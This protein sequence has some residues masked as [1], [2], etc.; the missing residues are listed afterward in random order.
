[1][2]KHAVRLCDA[3]F[4]NIYHLD[5]EALHLVATQNAPPAFAEASGLTT[6]RPGLKTPTGRM[7]ANKN[8]VH[9]ADLRAEKAYADRDPWIVAGVE[10]GGVRTVL[11]APMLKEQELIGA[12]SV[13][14]QKVQP[15]TDKQI[16]M[17]KL[18]RPSCHRH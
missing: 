14:R 3:E 8:V 7:I 10:L 6:G 11:M 18:C 2:L 12:F 13:Y 15:F 16:E 17:S 5:G 9:I 4:G 1:M